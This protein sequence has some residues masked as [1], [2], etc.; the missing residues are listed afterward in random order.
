[1]PV[2]VAGTEVLTD[3]WDIARYADRE[4]RGE[5][6]FA[7]GREAEI[8]R[9]NDLAETTSQS[10]RALVMAATFASPAALDA[11]LP[12]AV[13]AFVRPLLR[14]VTRSITKRFLQKYEVTL[15]DGEA[16]LR[17]VRAALDQIRAALAGRPYLLGSFSYA[18]IVAA[19]LLQGIVPVADRYLRL[20]PATRAAWTRRPLDTDF[21]DLVAWRD[22]LYE[23][24][25]GTRASA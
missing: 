18:D 19:T 1:V 2:L 23:K 3:S 8:R 16:P 12:P 5:K 10:G 14:P 21:A 6:L 20:P 4:G 15:G 13:P 17:T 11:N 24:H 7:P 25:R 22:G 9:W